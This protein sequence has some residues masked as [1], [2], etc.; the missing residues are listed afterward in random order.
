MGSDSIFRG[1]TASLA[2]AGKSSLTL[3]IAACVL[4]ACQTSQVG[5]RQTA[6][7]PARKSEPATEQLRVLNRVTFGA[8]GSAARQIEA[9]GIERYLEQQLKPGPTVLP[10]AVQT[11]IDALTISQR[12]LNDLVYALEQQRLDF[13]AMKDPE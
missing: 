6:E 4:A 7:G 10:A 8:N 5:T 9:A 12:P 2:R 13:S 1:R 11:Q 3:F